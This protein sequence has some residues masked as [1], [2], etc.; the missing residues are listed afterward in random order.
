MNTIN[1]YSVYNSKKLK[2][3]DLDK[4]FMNENTNVPTIAAGDL[5]AIHRIWNPYRENTNGK[6]LT[7]YTNSRNIVIHATEEPTR[8]P[9]IPKI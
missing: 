9:E 6:I 2:F 1:I 8:I 5:N 4:V 7:R 3:P